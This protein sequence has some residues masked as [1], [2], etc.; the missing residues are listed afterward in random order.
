[1]Y[2]FHDGKKQTEFGTKF[3]SEEICKINSRSYQSFASTSFLFQLF[4]ISSSLGEKI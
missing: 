2:T 4:Y 3:P 1:M